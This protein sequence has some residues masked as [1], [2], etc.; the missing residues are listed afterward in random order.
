MN[1]KL[2]STFFCSV[3][4]SSCLFAS[5][6]ETN[7]G[8][9]IELGSESRDSTTKPKNKEIE[10]KEFKIDLNIEDDSKILAQ[11]AWGSKTLIPKLTECRRT[12]PATCNMDPFLFCSYFRL[13]FGRPFF[14]F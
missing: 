11:S 13:I 6:R 9:L 14:D 8:E 3:F 4:M 12:A 2:K 10:F 7:V 5:E 1:L